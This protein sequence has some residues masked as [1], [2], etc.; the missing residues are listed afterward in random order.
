M[1]SPLKL[2]QV[3]MNPGPVLVDER[4]RQALSLP[5]LCHREPE[6][7]AL[8]TRVSRKVTQVCGGDGGYASVVF[9]GSGTA[10]LEAALSSIVPPG[11]K[12]LILDNGHYGERLEKIVAVHGIAH[13]VLRF[14]W[15]APFDLETI[16]SALGGDSTLTHIAMVH[17]ETSTGML[18]PLREVGRIAARHDRSLMVDAISSVGGEALDME[19]DHI[20]WCVGTANK[21]IEGIP[22]LSFV[23]AS[24]A[25]LDGLANA[26]RRTYYLDLYNQYVATDRLQAPPFTPAVQTFCAFDVALDLMLAEGV[27]ARH[28]RYSSLAA[29]LRDGLAGLGFRFLLTPEHRSACLT[30]VYLPDGVTYPALHDALKS[31]GFVIYAAQETLSQRVFRLA[32]MGQ[33]TAD[34]IARFLQVLRQVVSGDRG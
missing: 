27:A 20:D 29:Q 18:N 31:R 6:F 34:D 25:R 33:I 10:A 11:G 5:D 17:H 13:R 16:E 1:S 9:S 14:G 3:L 12:V 2:R 21:C 8:M 22:G 23:C 30:A 28:A 15:A 32:N 24:R 19:A 26:T 7:A 4:V